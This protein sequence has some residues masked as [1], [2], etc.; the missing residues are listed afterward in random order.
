MLSL[1]GIGDFQLPGIGEL[2]FDNEIL[3]FSY[4]IMWGA[5][6]FL[7]GRELNKRG[8]SPISLVVGVLV[9][10]ATSFTILIGGY[11]SYRTKQVQKPTPLTDHLPQQVEIIDAGYTKTSRILSGIVAGEAVVTVI[12]VMLSAFF[13][14]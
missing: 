14:I 12:W 1:Q 3:A 10:P 11:I 13:F 4:L 9:P 5:G 7:A 6:G 8:L 2:G